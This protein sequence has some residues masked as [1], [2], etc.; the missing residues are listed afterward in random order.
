MIL[1][2][3]VDYLDRH[4]AAFSFLTA[5]SLAGLTAA[6]VVLTARLAKAQELATRVSTEPVVIPRISLNGTSLRLTLINAS[7]AVASG[8]RAYTG[9]GSIATVRGP[10]S[11]LTLLPGE[12]AELDLDH[13]DLAESAADRT[14]LWGGVDI[15]Y[16]DVH[17]TVL[18]RTRIFVTEF[19]EPPARGDVVMQV[20]IARERHERK[21]LLKESE[22]QHTAKHQDPR[23]TWPLSSLWIAA[24]DPQEGLVYGRR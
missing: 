1:A 8:L 16:A 23:E 18:F 11:D 22:A 21:D 24:N 4:G 2:T 14:V 19:R 6:Y 13:P 10:T 17:E 20:G 7:H 15:L 9:S 3:V 5:L 12:S